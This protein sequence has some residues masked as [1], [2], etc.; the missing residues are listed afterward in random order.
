[1]RG[2]SDCFD[3]FMVSS[4]FA[5][6]PNPNRCV[7]SGVRDS[8]VLLFSYGQFCVG[9]RINIRQMARAEYRSLTQT[10]R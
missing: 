8:F 3:D 7:C 5:S 2:K 10:M 1:M 9:C 4:P 6:K